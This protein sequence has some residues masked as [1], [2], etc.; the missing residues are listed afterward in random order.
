MS[1]P[2]DPDTE[3]GLYRKYVV[4]VLD[5]PQG[6]H[7]DCPFFVL[8]PIHDP[9]ARVALQMYASLLVTHNPTTVGERFH[10][11]QTA[12]RV[13]RLNDPDGK[14]QDCPTFVLDPVHYPLDRVVLRAYAAMCVGS[15]PHLADDLLRLLAD[16]PLSDVVAEWEALATLNAGDPIPPDIQQRWDAETLAAQE[17][18]KQARAEANLAIWGT[19][20]ATGAPYGTTTDGLIR[21]LGEDPARRSFLPHVQRDVPPPPEASNPLSTRVQFIQDPVSVNPDPQVTDLEEWRVVQ[22]NKVFRLTKRQR[23]GRVGHPPYVG[24]SM[25]LNGIKVGSADG[26]LTKETAF[27]EIM[28]VYLPEMDVS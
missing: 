11:L 2:S 13:E 19:Y 28:E 6:E 26:S 25:V 3:R 9:M 17:Q 18:L 20:L 1:Q 10:R 5:D 24:W 12:Y 23:Q 22:H 15:Y 8:D 27:D 21:W 4:T 7:Q 14:H 16:H